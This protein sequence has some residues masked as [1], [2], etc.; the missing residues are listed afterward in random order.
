MSEPEARLFKDI[1][2][3][4]AQDHFRQSD[5]ALLCRYVE[6]AVMAD[7]AAEEL[8]QAPVVDGKP[9]PWLVIQEKS[10]RAL[11]ALSLRLRLSPQARR[12]KPLPTDK[13]L[14]YSDRVRLQASGHY[15]DDDEFN[16]D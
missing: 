1:V 5:L 16:D 2:A 11:T 7:R 9:S 3:S 8:R 12:P 13:P 4:C 14:T 15:D 10:V 6:A